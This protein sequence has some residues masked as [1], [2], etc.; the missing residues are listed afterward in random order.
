MRFYSF[1]FATLFIF[2]LTSCTAPDSQ[3][4]QT[5][6][7]TPPP[8]DAPVPAP[9]ANPI[10]EPPPA[11]FYDES[12]L[13]VDPLLNFDLISY[14]RTET[15]NLNPNQVRQLNLDTIA[16]LYALP[17]RDPRLSTLPRARVSR[18]D[19]KLA[20]KVIDSMARHPV[21]A[22][23]Q[24]FKYSQSRTIIG[25]CFGRATYAHLT[26]LRMGMAKESIRKAWLV[27]P[28]QAGSIHW[29]FHV[30]TIVKTTDGK[31]MVVD[32]YLGRLTEVKDWA[33]SFYPQNKK[34][35]NLRL[36]VTSP[37]KFSVSLSSYSRLQMGLDLS[38]TKD[39]Y[40]NYFHDMME[41]FKHH[42]LEEIGLPSRIQQ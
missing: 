40:R 3:A 6:L 8:V 41:W 4:P 11:P 33:E 34:F 22:S 31:W 5:P 32:D 25:Y 13:P 16:A 38:P 2:G 30:A 29:A 24:D 27:G 7:A 1:L 19:P 12:P 15:K 10:L 36:Y 18:I 20:Q 26:L 9:E 28:M 37:E 23:S 21:V 39:W 17:E 14:Q 42:S 35:Q